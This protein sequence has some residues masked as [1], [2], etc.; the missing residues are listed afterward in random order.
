MNAQQILPMRIYPNIFFLLL[1]APLFAQTTE[2][3][4]LTHLGLEPSGGSHTASLS[5]DGHSFAFLSGA[6]DLVPNDT[7]YQ[8][9]AF[10]RNIQTGMVTRVSVSSS[11]VEGDGF[12][13]E[14][15]LSADGKWAAFIDESDNLVPSGAAWSRDAYLHELSS[16]LTTRVSADSFGV[17]GNDRSDSVAISA[18]GRYVVFHSQATNLVV[19]DTNGVE[20][21]FLHDRITGTTERISTGLSGAEANGFST[22]PYISPDGRFVTFRSEATNLVAN[23]ANGRADAFLLDRLSGE[24]T[25]VSV[26]SLGVQ[27]N[28]ASRPGGISADGRFITLRSSATNLIPGGSSN[29]PHIYLRDL[30]LGL[31]TFISMDSAG[32]PSNGICLSPSVSTSGRFVFYES[33]ADNLV[34]GDNNNKPD[35]FLHDRETAETTMIAVNNLGTYGNKAGYRPSMS[36]NGRYILFDSNSRNLVPGDNNGMFDVFLR[37]RAETAAFNHILL[38]GPYEAPT[39]AP[40]QLTWCAAPP[41]SPY[42]LHYS[43]NLNGTVFAGHSFDI[44]SPATLLATGFTAADGQGS[45]TTQNVPSAAAGFTVYFEQVVRSSGQF[46]ESIVQPIQFH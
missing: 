24:T 46:Y 25:L 43:L 6:D 26:S 41:N 15:V 2:R 4:S 38:W 13:A 16:G 9:D 35:I 32:V 42:Y 18:D 30:K 31:T 23:D 10:V 40:V 5:A 20:D 7:N 28:N 27:G 11:G 29:G 21:V 3:V 44:G 37:D 39:G 45:V 1:S 33:W 19:G 12:T 8:R 17:Q 14:V 34:V 36:S 22:E